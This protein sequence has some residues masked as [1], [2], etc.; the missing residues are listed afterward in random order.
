[1]SAGLRNL[2]AIMF[3]GAL[4]AAARYGAAGWIQRQSGARFPWGTLLVNLAACFLLGF[5]AGRWERSTAP[6][7]WRLMW[8]VGF[9]GAFST[10]STFALETTHLIRD[11]WWSGVGTYLALHLVVGVAAV[12]LGMAA[13]RWP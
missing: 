6:A 7:A 11:G 12:F 10:Y 5:L 9:L 8:G 3:G 2:V 1:M 4:G 13:S